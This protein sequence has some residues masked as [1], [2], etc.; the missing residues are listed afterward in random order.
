MRPHP[1]SLEQPTTNAE[2]DD[3]LGNRRSWQIRKPVDP[4][5]PA[6]WKA[7]VARTNKELR[8][9]AD[10]LACSDSI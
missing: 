10:V 4:F 3:S 1:L 6:T 8:T 7:L 9:L 2:V 5:K